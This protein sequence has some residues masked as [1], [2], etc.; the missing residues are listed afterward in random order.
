VRYILKVRVSRTRTR[1]EGTLV[2][3]ARAYPGIS[4]VTATLTARAA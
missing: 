4:A 2:I 3:R 1:A